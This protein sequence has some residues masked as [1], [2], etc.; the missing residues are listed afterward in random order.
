MFVLSGWQVHSNE[1]YSYFG[2]P[3][4]LKA[5]RANPSWEELTISLEG[6]QS[7]NVS[8]LHSVEASYQINEVTGTV[9]STLPVDFEI[10][11]P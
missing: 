10:R 1:V 5:D 4:F 2:W 11:N 8:Y 9:N 3:Y 6:G 7:Y